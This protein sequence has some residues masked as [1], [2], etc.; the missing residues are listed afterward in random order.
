MDDVLGEEEGWPGWAQTRPTLAK[1]ETLMQESEVAVQ[2]GASSVKSSESTTG[3]TSLGSRT[4]RR[5]SSSDLGRPRGHGRNRT[6]PR[7]ESSRLP[8]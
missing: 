6:S 8:R 7:K 1:L 3:W 2:L 5:I 4:P